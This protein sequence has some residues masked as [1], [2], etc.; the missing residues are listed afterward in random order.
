MTKHA[1]P[2]RKL[3]ATLG[4]LAILWGCSGGDTPDGSADSTDTGKRQFISV[5]SAP[6]GGMFYLVGGAISD[7]VNA[8]AP[9]LNWK[10][11]N[12]STGGSQENIVLLD[13]GD[14]QF[15]ISNS[16]ISYFAVRGEGGWD[17]AYDIRAVMTMFAN[18]AM[19][20]TKKDSG[21]T[22]IADLKGKRVSVGPQGA[23]FEYFIR[24]LIQAHG[25]TYD[26]FQQVYGSQLNSV[27]YLKD[28]S[29]DAAFLGGGVPTSSITQ[30]ATTMNI[31][32]IPYGDAEKAQ[33]IEQYP[34]FNSATI[35]AGTY[36]GTDEEYNGLNVGSAHIITHA[37]AT[38]EQVYQFTKTVYESR[39]QLVEKVK[40]A[41]AINPKNV[42][43]NT[44][45][46]FHPGAIRY[47]TEIGIWPTDQ[48]PAGESN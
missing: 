20:I 15:A 9:E 4:A 18:V 3:S 43:V 1:R 8:N 22:T 27:D 7:V 12:E 41:R 30:A 35:P 21:L 47:Y 40:A 42:V 19:F 45:T 10:V 5:G 25:V 16:S 14:I 26:D 34:F 13:K 31:S 46:E 29:I 32:L 39:E 37:S 24:P 38:D 11:T 44:G 28:G 33:L 17:K 36:K 48:P 23:G 6:I 2:F